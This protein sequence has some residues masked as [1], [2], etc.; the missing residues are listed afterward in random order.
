[1]DEQC[2]CGGIIVETA[3]FGVYRCISCGEIYPV[4]DLDSAEE[5]E[6]D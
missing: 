3:S 6:E 1:M 2:W 5:E 4:N